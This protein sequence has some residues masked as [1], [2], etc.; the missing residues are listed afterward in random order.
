MHLASMLSL[1]KHGY[2]GG[3]GVDIG[4]ETLVISI[5]LIYIYNNI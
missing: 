3:V 5:G 4:G 1:V 2:V